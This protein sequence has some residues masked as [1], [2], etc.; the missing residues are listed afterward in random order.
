VLDL[1]EKQAGE[2]EEGDEDLP[3]LEDVEAIAKEV[4]KALRSYRQIAQS[5]IANQ[6]FP[7]AR[8]VL[9]TSVAKT[10]KIGGETIQMGYEL[11]RY[12]LSSWSWVILGAVL[13]LFMG[14]WVPLHQSIS[15]WAQQ[16]ASN[17][18]TRWFRG[19]V[20]YD[21]W[22]DL[23]FKSKNAAVGGVG[24]FWFLL[25]QICSTGL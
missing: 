21:I 23:I 20:E 14:E 25:V 17:T 13:A 4:P 1:G 8:Q 9:R 10:L 15:E 2:K 16:T 7:V 19:N 11:A 22:K 18:F 3:P 5:I 6:I 24:F 12:V